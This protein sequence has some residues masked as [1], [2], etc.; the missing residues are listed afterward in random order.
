MADF[1]S[2]F[3][4]KDESLFQNVTKDRP[5]RVA[6][7]CL[8]YPLDGNGAPIYR[9]KQAGTYHWYGTLLMSDFPVELQR[10]EA[11]N[12]I[13]LLKMMHLVWGTAIL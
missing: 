12:L 7:S 2:L 13:D 4:V 8:F 11:N 10:D 5:A 6:A 3:P 9:Y 1:L